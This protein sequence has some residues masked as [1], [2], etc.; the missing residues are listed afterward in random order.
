M[1]QYFMEFLKATKRFHKVF[2][3]IENWPEK[4]LVL[5]CPY[6]V[7]VVLQLEIKEIKNQ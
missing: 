1:N 5:V 6:V 7:V 4:V 2:Q 3:H